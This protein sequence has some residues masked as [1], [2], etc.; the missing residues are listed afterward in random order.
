MKLNQISHKKIT[1][2]DKKIFKALI[3]LYEEKDQQGIGP[4]EIGLRVGRDR[5]DA[6]A[7]CNLSL[8]KLV[9]FEL[10]KRTQEGKYIP[11]KNKM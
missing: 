2:K 10:V 6:S 9:F 11:L 7:Y 5:Y 1:D 3:E 4:T 8:K